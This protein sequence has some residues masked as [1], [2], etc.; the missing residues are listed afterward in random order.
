MRKYIGTIGLAALLA[1]GGGSAYA[2]RS[3][4]PTGLT[5]PVID[6]D[7]VAGVQVPGLVKT[8]AYT[9]VA[10]D[11]GRNI[12]VTTAATIT[13]SSAA[14]LGDGFR[15]RVFGDGVTATVAIGSD[16][17]AVLTGK[18]VEVWVVNGKRWSSP[19]STAGNTPS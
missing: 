15:C 9:V 10:T 11:N 7:D 1:L 16:N 19:I 14:I 5:N 8:A 18:Y 6:G 3:G 2:T 13:F 12:D 17:L 4:N